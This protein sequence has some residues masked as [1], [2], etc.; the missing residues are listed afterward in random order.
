MYSSD[1]L[2]AISDAISDIKPTKLTEAYTSDNTGPLSV[3]SNANFQSFEN[4]GIGTTNSGYIK[5]GNEI[6][7]YTTTGT[8]SGS[9]GGIITRGSNPKNYAVGT[10]V[11]KYELNG[12]SLKRINKTHDLSDVTVSNPITFD[13]YNIKVGMNTD[14]TDRTTSSGWPNLYNKSTKSSGGND[15]RA[16]QN[17]PFEIITPMVQNVTVPG[18]T[19]TGMIR[20]VSGKSISGNEI[21]FADKGWE[22]VS[23]NVQNFVD[24]PRV[25]CSEVNQ[26]NKLTALPGSKSFQLSIQLASSD[27]K[28]SPIIDT[29]RINTILTSSRVNS[30][31]DD[32]ATDKRGNSAT[33]DPTA[34]QYISKEITLENAATSLQVTINANMNPYTDIR[35]F[36]AISESDNFDPVFTPF[37]GYDNLNDR[38]EMIKLEDSS[39][40]SDAYVPLPE[41]AASEDDLWSEH[42]FSSKELP[43]FRSY[44]IKFVM[45]STSQVYAPSAKDLRVI[46]LA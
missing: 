22:T 36:Y 39:G 12:I 25:I 20:T 30:I 35:A 24:T 43:T 44:R 5:I 33:N 13:S 45:T 9:L 2:V 29:Q 23:L 8:G 11:Y 17:M 41:N 38:G 40:R 4:I 1:N 15:I 32:Y 21:P 3:D 42:T 19:L 37:P 28:I 18:T 46:A 16:T 34:M 6:I 14:G 31:I 7:G 10:P 26:N 27:T